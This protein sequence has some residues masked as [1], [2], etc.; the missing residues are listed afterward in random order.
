MKFNGFVGYNFIGVMEIL[1]DDYK[2]KSFIE[3]AVRDWND[4]YVDEI[5]VAYPD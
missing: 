5:L 4:Y 3:N 2:V 1:M